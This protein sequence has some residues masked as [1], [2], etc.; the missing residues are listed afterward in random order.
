MTCVSEE[1]MS[2]LRVASREFSRIE[3]RLRPAR[4]RLHAAII[5]ERREGTSVADIVD[6]SPYRR[7]RVTDILDQAGLVQK[8]TKPDETADA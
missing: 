5:A 1:T 7:G 6:I 3:E 2:E 8:K 4:T